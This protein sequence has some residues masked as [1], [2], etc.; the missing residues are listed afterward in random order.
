MTISPTAPARDWTPDD[1][2]APAGPAVSPLW[3]V[4]DVA[5][6]VGVPV[7]TVYTW[8]S[9]GAGPRGFRVGKHVRYRAEDVHEWVTEQIAKDADR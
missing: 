2:V 8:R 9:T 1:S 7:K 4:D 3:S 6:Y 5:A